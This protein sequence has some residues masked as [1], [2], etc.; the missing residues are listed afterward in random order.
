VRCSSAKTWA[1]VRESSRA[2]DADAHLP[3]PVESLAVEIDQG[4]EGRGEE[5]ESVLD[6]ALHTAF[7]MPRAGRQG[8]VAK[9]SGR[10]FE[11]RGW[12]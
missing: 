9:C 5:C 11:K 7:F 4:G 6:G 10:E 8:R 1:T 12:K 3:A 2:K